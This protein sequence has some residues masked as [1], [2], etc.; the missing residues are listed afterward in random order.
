MK[1]ELAGTHDV[2]QGPFPENGGIKNILVVIRE[3][4]REEL[5]LSGRGEDRVTVGAEIG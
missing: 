2:S 4:A 3:R 1:Q 5:R